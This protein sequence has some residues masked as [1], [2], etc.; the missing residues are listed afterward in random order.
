[1]CSLDYLSCSWKTERSTDFHKDL[2]TKLRLIVVCGLA[3]IKTD[4]DDPPF[5]IAENL[6]VKEVQIQ[7]VVL[8]RGSIQFDV[9]LV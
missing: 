2:Q 7:N 6:G 1:M 3:C 5:Q 8:S 4:I 9:S